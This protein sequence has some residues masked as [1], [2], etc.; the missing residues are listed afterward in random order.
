MFYHE[1]FVNFDLFAQ[2]YIDV[3]ILSL[4]AMLF[5]IVI[6]SIVKLENDAYTVCC[7]LK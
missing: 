3:R 4:N 7:G 2:L 5:H 6:Y 1:T